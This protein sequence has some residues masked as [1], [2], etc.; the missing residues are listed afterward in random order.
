[1]VEKYHAEGCDVLII[2][3][4]RHPEVEGAAGRV[5][6]RVHVIASEEEADDVQVVD[7]ERVAYVTQTTLSQSDIGEIRQRLEQRFPAIRGPRSNVCYATQNRQNVVKELARKADILLVVGSKS[8][9]NSNRLR[10]VGCRAGMTGYLIDDESDI[11]PEWLQ[12]HESVGVTAGA[13]APE[14]L[15]RGVVHWLQQYGATVVT[16]LPGKEEQVSFQPA[17][18]GNN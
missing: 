9:S 10:E 13:S 18:L 3:H 5:R 4:H 7:P 6:G 8:S 15:V 16:E 11:R 2:G 17:V 1:M 14:R 12:G